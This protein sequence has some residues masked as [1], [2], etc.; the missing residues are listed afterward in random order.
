MRPICVDEPDPPGGS[1]RAHWGAVM[2]SYRGAH[3]S[4][5]GPIEHGDASPC[6]SI[7]RPKEGDRL[8]SY[9]GGC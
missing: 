5:P 4:I 1:V 9:L 3:D 7:E 2:P 8:K 6:G